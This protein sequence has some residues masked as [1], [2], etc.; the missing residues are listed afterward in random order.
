M[1]EPQGDPCTLSLRLWSV[2]LVLPEKGKPHGIVFWSLLTHTSFPIEAASCV[3][4]ANSGSEELVFTVFTCSL[5]IRPVPQ[6]VGTLNTH[7][8]THTRT[9]THPAVACPGQAVGGWHPWHPAVLWP[10]LSA[11]EKLLAGLTFA[12][13][14]LG[15]RKGRA[16][17]GWLGQHAKDPGRAMTCQTMFVKTSALVWGWATC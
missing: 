5:L 3:F 4:A 9:E 17:C 11:L 10:Q 16:E 15:F 2:V 12:S 6:Q 7:T 8:H 1:T 14:R 13:M